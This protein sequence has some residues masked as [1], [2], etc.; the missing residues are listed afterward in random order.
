MERLKQ[1]KGPLD[2]VMV[3]D[4]TRALAGPYGSLILG[5]LGAEVIKIE[6]PQEVAL[7]FGSRTALDPRYSYGGEDVYFLSVNRNKKSLTLNLKVPQARQ[8]FYDLTKK[9]DVVF[10]NFRPGVMESLGIDYE[11]L[12]KINPR[13]ISCSLTG[14][15][16][17]GP[18]EER[19]AFDLIIQALSGG[20]SITGD[21]DPDSPPIRAGI[22]VADLGGGMF[23]AHGIMAALYSRER[24][25]EGQKVD[26]SLLDGQISMLGYVAAYYLISGVIQGRLG[27]RHQNNPVYGALKTMDGYVAICAHRG[28]FWKN[29]CRS[30]N[31]EEL[32]NDPRFNSDLTRHQ[33]AGEIWDLLGKIF[34]TRTTSEWLGRLYECDVPCAPINSVDAALN[35]PQVLHN[36]MIVSLKRPEGGEIKLVGNPI[37]MSGTVQQPYEY[38][39]KLGQNTEE[40]LQGVLGYSEQ[41]I[42]ELKRNQA[43]G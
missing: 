35:D 2:G 40:I 36:N 4:L 12:K 20:I 37:K 5:D 8:V 42:Q 33:N 19:P 38:P 25:G 15:G 30:M 7:E 11:S 22:A 32:I 39:V 1:T 3:L 10:D 6:T 13:I 29:L 43:I 27:T 18:Y 21:S 28:P 17:D 26:V 34:A 9:A 14:F 31:R 23:A 41:Q 16:P 24:T